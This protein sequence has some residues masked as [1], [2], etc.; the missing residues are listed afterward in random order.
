MTEIFR[1]IFVCTPE[2]KDIFFQT[3]L[4]SNKKNN[5]YQESYE[6]RS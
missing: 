6:Y 2:K 5:L 1:M 4:G 3:A